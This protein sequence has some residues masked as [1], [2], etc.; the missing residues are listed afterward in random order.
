MDSFGKLL[1][2]LCQ[3]G[4][5]LLRMEPRYRRQMRA[6]LSRMSTPLRLRDDAAGLPLPLPEFL[7]DAYA[8][9]E[10]LG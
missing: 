2:P 1:T 8:H 9:P 5:R 10:G 3:R 4:I 6:H 7:H